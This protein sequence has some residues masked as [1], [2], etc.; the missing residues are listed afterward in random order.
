MP[1]LS[2]SSVQHPL[3]SGSFLR[4]SLRLQNKLELDAADMITLEREISLLRELDHPNIVKLHRVFD[5]PYKLYMLRNFTRSL[6][7]LVISHHVLT[8]PVLLGLA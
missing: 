6:L 1:W 7:L 2:P 5:T 3:V 8:C 4:D